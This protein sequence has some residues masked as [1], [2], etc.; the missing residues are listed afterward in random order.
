MRSG[1]RPDTGRRVAID[2]TGSLS[3]SAESG[4]AW[5]GNTAAGG[6]CGLFCHRE[7]RFAHRAWHDG[8]RDYT[9]WFGV[10]WLGA[11]AP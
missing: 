10:R 4:A 7:G 8:N 2:G 1:Q 9:D 3:G 6:L 5:R 11:A